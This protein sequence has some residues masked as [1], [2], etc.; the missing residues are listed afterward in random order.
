MNCAPGAAAARGLQPRM[1][2]VDG[3]KGENLRLKVE[4][5]GFL[6]QDK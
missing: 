6:H 2:G 5:H 1:I 3:W 4:T